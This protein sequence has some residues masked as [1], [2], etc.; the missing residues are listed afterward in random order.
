MTGTSKSVTL[1]SSSATG[2]VS[3]IC[4]VNVPVSVPPLPS[5][6][7]YGTCTVP[8]KPGSGVNAVS[9][10]FGSTNSV[11]PGLPVIGSII[12]IGPVDGSTPLTS[13]M[14]SGS[15]LGSVSLSSRFA[16]AVSP[17]GATARSSFA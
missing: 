14:L 15:P 10:V 4:T 12:V 9:P 7:V 11:P 17:T 16:V 5:S 3:V 6:T 8:V 13:V 2:E 1:L